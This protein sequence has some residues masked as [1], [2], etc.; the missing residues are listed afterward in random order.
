MTITDAPNVYDFV[1]PAGKTIV[2]IW[3]VSTNSVAWDMAGW[4]ST[5]LVKALDRFGIVL[6]PVI[7][8]FTC[9]YDVASKRWTMTL[10]SLQSAGVPPGLN[11][12][13]DWK[14]VRPDGYVYVP[15]AG[16]INVLRKVS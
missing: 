12:A 6:A 7:M 5:M 16:T 13:W 3:G 8:Q 9:S 4:S 10:P 15:L 14:L 2:R 11:Y 1:F